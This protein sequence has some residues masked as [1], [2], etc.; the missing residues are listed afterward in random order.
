MSGDICVG[1]PGGMGILL[2]ILVVAMV[3]G[4][5]GWLGWW[6]WRVVVV[7]FVLVWC[8]LVVVCSKN[9]AERSCCGAGLYSCLLLY[10]RWLVGCG[11][12]GVGLWWGG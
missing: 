8:W 7:G 12:F 3:V 11:G 4:G 2:V 1:D 9:G 6:C 10:S 5:G